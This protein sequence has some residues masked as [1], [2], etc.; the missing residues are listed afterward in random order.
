MQFDVS[1]GV[2]KDNQKLL[3][4]IDQVLARHQPAIRRLLDSYRVPVIEP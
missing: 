1:V 3:K 4:D 2:R